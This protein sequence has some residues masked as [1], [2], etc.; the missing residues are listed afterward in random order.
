MDG[1]SLRD[2]LRRERQLPVPDA[3]AILREMADALEHAHTLG[4]IHRDIKPE[5]ILLGGGHAPGGLRDRTGRHRRARLV[6]RGA[7][8]DRSGD[9][10]DGL[11]QSQQAAGAGELDRRT[12][13][14]SLAAVAYEMLAG[15]P[16]HAA[17]TAEAMQARK[18]R[19]PASSLRIV[20]ESVS[21]EVD[22]AIRKALAKV[23]A[24]R[25]STTRQFAE[26]L[27]GGP[28][29]GGAA[30]IAEP[31]S[32]ELTTAAVTA[33][34][35]K[36]SARFSGAAYLLTALI[37]AVLGAV[38]FWFFWRDADARW[39]ASDAL[40]KIERY[41]DVADFE[42]AFALANEIKRRRPDSRELAE[43][44]PR[45]S[46]KVTIK[47]EPAG[48]RVLRQHNAPPDKWEDLGQTPLVDVRF[49]WG[50]SRLRFEHQ[51]YRPLIRAI[52]GAHFN[53]AELTP[54]N[55]DGLL[56]G[57]ETFTLDT[58]QT[59]PADKVRVPAWKFPDRGQT[60]DASDFLLDRYE[61]TNAEY[62]KFVDAGGYHR[63]EWW[64]PVKVRGRDLMWEEAMRLFVDRTGRPGPSTWV[65]GDHR[66]GQGAWPVSGLSWYEAAAYA[67][68]AGQALPTAHHW[69]EALANS[70]FP[71]L[72]PAS[73]FGGSGPRPGSESRA[74]THV[75]A[76]DM[77]GNV[78]EWT[79]TAIGAERII[80]GGSW[81]D[82][83]YVAGTADELGAA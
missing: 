67:R 18:L 57:P 52:G 54:G 82:P 16:P 66:E 14:Y 41:L 60:I 63:R 1:E 47:S 74:M 44:W 83:Y 3:V 68:Y 79:S 42:S 39:L 2:R 8:R 65:A 20:R 61:V 37:A 22:N 69:Q 55:P 19:E 10:D 32:S 5:N 25:F 34:P 33:V 50:L 28:E 59:L 46:W 36:R 71:W 13:I 76:F 27:T 23:P 70:M 51:G 12:D 62:K 15:Q 43:L 26:A 45:F 35:A 6:P 78:R 31:R 38:G 73:N 81:S 75:G 9:R 21:P 17:A 56:V 48:A 24:D 77:T 4:V 58:E 64:E 49:P 72:L 11:H 80:L 53:W 40:P 30:R 29:S 7:D